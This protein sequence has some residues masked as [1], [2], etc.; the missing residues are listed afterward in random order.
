VREGRGWKRGSRR[1]GDE[2]KGGRGACVCVCCVVWREDVEP[3]GVSDLPCSSTRTARPPLF[4]RDLQGLWHGA[5]KQ[6]GRCGGSLRSPQQHEAGRPDD[7]RPAGQVRLRRR[8]WK[9]AAEAQG[10]Q[11]SGQSHQLRRGARLG[12]ASAAAAG[13]ALP[14]Q[15]CAAAAASRLPAEAR[16]SPFPSRSPRPPSLALTFSPP[17]F[18]S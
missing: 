6:P 5:A 8:N 4:M 16:R 18:S 10:G 3:K 9:G 7:Q 13:V 2:G 17:S 12:A 15:P 1:R 11:S 14:G